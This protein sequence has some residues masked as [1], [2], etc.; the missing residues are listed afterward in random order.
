MLRK[1]FE[2]AAEKMPISVMTRLLM[3]PIFDTEW[4]DALFE[5]HRERQY[6]RELLFSTVVKMMS[7]VTLGVC[8]FVIHSITLRRHIKIN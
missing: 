4:I 2:Q 3:G 1:L 5:K 6:S 8:Q 7:M